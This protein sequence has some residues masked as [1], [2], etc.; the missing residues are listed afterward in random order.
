MKFSAT[1]RGTSP[2]GKRC[3]GEVKD[4]NDDGRWWCV[5]CRKIWTDAIHWLRLADEI[6][7]AREDERVKAKEAKAKVKP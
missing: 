6:E 4:W 5:K 2:S 7:E 3:D 1:C